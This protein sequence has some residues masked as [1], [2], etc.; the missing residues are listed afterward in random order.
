[1]PPIPN[2]EV[3]KPFYQVVQSGYGYPWLVESGGC[4]RSNFAEVTFAVFPVC[5]TTANLLA[6]SQKYSVL[7]FDIDQTQLSALNISILRDW[8]QTSNQL[9]QGLGFQIAGHISRVM[10][11]SQQNSIMAQRLINSLQQI[12]NQTSRPSTVNVSVLVRGTRQFTCQVDLNQNLN[13]ATS[14]LSQIR[15]YPTTYKNLGFY[16][17]QIT[18]SW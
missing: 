8:I 3:A 10:N 4:V 5:E 15:Q 6:N 2:L 18:V 11:Q 9:N 12:A 16:I 7:Y 13:Q 17:D 14:C 1:L